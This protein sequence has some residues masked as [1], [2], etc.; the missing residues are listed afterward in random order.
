M[1][2]ATYLT[3]IEREE[4]WGIDKKGQEVYIHLQRQRDNHRPLNFGSFSK[5]LDKYL[6]SFSFRQLEFRSCWFGLVCWS[7]LGIPQW[8]P[9]LEPVADWCDCLGRRARRASPPLA[10]RTA[11][12]D[13]ICCL[14]SRAPWLLVTGAPSSFSWPRTLWT[15]AAA[16][17][18][19]PTSRRG[20]AAASRRHRHRNRR[21][22]A[23]ARR[24]ATHARMDAT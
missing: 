16:C 21:G 4:T 20:Q 5:V 13:G 2:A 8:C 7:L 17:R 15:T 23:G 10:T 24:W 1:R 12:C 22:A 6:V 3:R 14:V 18:M 19:S 11:L 9:L